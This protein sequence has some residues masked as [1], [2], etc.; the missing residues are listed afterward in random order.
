M[1]SYPGA[2][3]SFTNPTGTDGLDD[4]I[5]GRTHAAM[6]ADINDEMEAV[7]AELGVGPAGSHATVVARLTAGELARGATLTRS[8][9]QS[10][11]NTTLTDILWTT[12]TE[13]T[14]A[15]H[16]TSTDT[17][18]F[19][20][21]SGL[22]GLYL[23]ALVLG[24]TAHS[25]ASRSAIIYKNTTQIS[26]IGFPAYAS[27]TPTLVQNTTVVRLAAGDY[28]KAAGYQSSGGALDLLHTRSSLSV[29]RIGV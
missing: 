8:A 16:S 11:P 9:A 21:P 7:Q 26:D 5:G 10:I 1:A 24:Y 17:A 13:D 18:R 3:V 14:D 29:Y 4:S 25:T 19:T 27:P 28:V 6:H 22:D 20:V 12:E 2:V 15:F 23:V